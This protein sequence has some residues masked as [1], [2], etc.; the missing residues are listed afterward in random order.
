MEDDFIGDLLGQRNFTESG[1]QSK[2]SFVKHLIFKSNLH[3]SDMGWVLTMPR[4]WK[5]DADSLADH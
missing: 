2:N 4:L 1:E 3:R 5:S